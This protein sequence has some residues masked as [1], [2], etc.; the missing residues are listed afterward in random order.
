MI[1]L[2]TSMKATSVAFIDVAFMRLQIVRYPV[3]MIV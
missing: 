2:P 1:L 3:S